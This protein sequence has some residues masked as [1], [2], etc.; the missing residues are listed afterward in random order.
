[1]S[2]PKVFIEIIDVL[3]DLHQVFVDPLGEC[4]LLHSVPFISKVVESL[5]E[6]LVLVRVHALAQAV[7]VQWLEG[8]TMVQ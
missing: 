4:F 1:M 6:L 5:Q 2:I 3:A 8:G 7:L